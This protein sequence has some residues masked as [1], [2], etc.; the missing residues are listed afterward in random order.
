MREKFLRFRV[1][2]SSWNVVEASL[3][4][5]PKYAEKHGLEYL[6]SVKERGWKIWRKHELA[7]ILIGP[8]DKINKAD[9]DFTNL[10]KR[11]F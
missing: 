9:E 11:A 7:F 6:T 3:R 4:S 2:L 10:Y 1:R 8:E 5:I